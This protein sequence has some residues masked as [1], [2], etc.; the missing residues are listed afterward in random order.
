MQMST[1]CVCVC[2]CVCLYVCV[3]VCMC[4]CV[5]LLI[6]LP[7]CAL[8]SVKTDIHAD[9]L[10][11]R[12]GSHVDRQTHHAVTAFANT[13]THSHRDWNEPAGSQIHM[14]AMVRDDC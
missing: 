12:G 5:C 10:A 6:Y 9:H 14:A 3:C 8:P 1:S 13:N 4:V 11:E 2:V 7:T